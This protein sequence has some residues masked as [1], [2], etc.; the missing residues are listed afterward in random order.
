LLP[1]VQAAREAAR[2]SQCQSNAKQIALAV[3]NYSDTH[4]GEL[5]TGGITNGPC[6]G[7]K[8]KESWSILILPYLEQQNLYDLYDFD[9]FNE[10]EVNWPVL[11]T[12]IPAYLCPSDEETDTL[13]R[14]QSARVVTS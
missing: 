12:I 2:R 5:P 8:S 10:D 9:A 3:V 11:Q 14:P 13:E 4:A 1:A 6:C 7:T